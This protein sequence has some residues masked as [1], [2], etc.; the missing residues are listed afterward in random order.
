MKVII[1][2]SRANGEIYAPPSKSLSHRALICGA[3]S[4]QSILTNVTV[5]PLSK[6]VGATLN[7]LMYLGANI[8]AQ[9]TKVKIGN[10][11][12]FNAKPETELDCCESG[13]TLRCLIPLCLLSGEK[14]TLV[15]AK[16]LFERPLGVYENICKEQGMLFEKGEASL[17][18]CGKLKSGCYRVPGDVSSQFITGLLFALPLLDGISIIE[19]TGKFES[20]SYIDL[21]LQILAKF[22]I[23]ITRNQN[24][25]VILGNQRYRN[26]EFEVESDCSNAAFLYALDYLGGDVKVLGINENT[27]QGDR[28]FTEIIADMDKGIREFDLSDCP[29]LAPILFAVAAAKGGGVFNGTARLRIKESDRASAMKQELEKFGIELIVEE[30]RVTVKNGTLTKPKE[31]LYG[32]NDHRIVMALSVLCTLTG[33]EIEGAEA[34]AKSYNGFFKDLKKLKVNLE[35][36]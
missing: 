11:D 2:P 5:G 29:D 3:L 7:C 8:C 33:G 31:L 15:G 22:G 10:L 20:A 28:V 24:R 27:L 34:V 16:R 13:S 25:L 4:G 6:D 30:N 23:R 1:R 19:I 36:K 14:I 21:T 9:G 18:V 35:Q 32:H 17:T 12:P 26:S